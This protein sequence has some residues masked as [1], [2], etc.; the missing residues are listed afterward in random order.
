MNNDGVHQGEQKSVIADGLYSSEH[1][2]SETT[3][4]IRNEMFEGNLKQLI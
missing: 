3:W 1:T 4:E 2:A